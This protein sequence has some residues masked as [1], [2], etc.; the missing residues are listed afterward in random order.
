MS[1]ID[2][3]FS[4]ICNLNDWGE[5][6]RRDFSIIVSGAYT[7]VSK[8][9]DPS[10]IARYFHGKELR[11]RTDG[12]SVGSLWFPFTEKDKCELMQMALEGA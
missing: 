8:S 4:F 7:M 12:L 6:H 3:A 10:T 2:D 1:G 5:M 11:I 9:S